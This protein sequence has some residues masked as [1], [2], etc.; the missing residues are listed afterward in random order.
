MMTAPSRIAEIRKEIPVSSN[1]DVVVGG[2]GPA[3]LAAAISAAR[4]G[5]KVMLIEEHGFLGGTCTA[6]MVSS[7]NNWERPGAPEMEGVYQ[8]LIDRL[9]KSDGIV[10]SRDGERQRFFDVEA[11]KY[12]LDEMM[13][14][15]GVTVLFHTMITDAVVDH[16]RVIG[17]VAQ[18]K[19]GRQV[20]LG[21]VVVD[22]TGDA[23]IAF[24]AGVLCT[25]GREP[26]GLM[27]P[28][29]LKMK[30][31]NVNLDRLETYLSEH[32]KEVFV[33]AHLKRT[34]EGVIEE[35]PQMK[36]GKLEGQFLGRVYIGFPS[37]VQKAKSEGFPLFTDYVHFHATPRPGEVMVNMVRVRG[38]DATGAESVS[39]AEVE[40]RK[41]VWVLVKFLKKYIPGFEDCY[42]IQT[43]SHIG[44]RESRR[45][46]GEHVLAQEEVE[47]GVLFPDTIATAYSTMLDVHDP[48][49]KGF[50]IFRALDHPVHIPYRSLIPTQK[51]GLIVAGRCISATHVAISAVRS[52]HKVMAAGQAAG[53]AAALSVKHN[54]QPR[55]LPVELVQA[56]L[57]R[58]GV[59]FG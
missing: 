36:F 54:V 19:S 35:V 25:K 33:Q 20:I 43:A 7:W 32:P 31:G 2:G 11:L 30:L 50:T 29:T 46:V 53:I 41:Q 9:K 39:K 14:E 4:A 13:D 37:A 6:G 22:A 21:R 42:L 47:K 12:V 15:V 24:S 5:A 52:T 1:T 40:G 57:R 16:D 34:Y 10:G 28:A 3:G 44:L 18:N 55:A 58:Q 56:E 59:N 27:Q 49:G 51:D 38:V 17:V 23:D 26:D 8:E 48:S 45:I